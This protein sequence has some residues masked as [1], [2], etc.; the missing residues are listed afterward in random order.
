MMDP[1]I[2]ELNPDTM[3]QEQMTDLLFNSLSD[4]GKSGDCIF[5]FGS[6]KASQYRLPKAIQLYREGRANKI[7]FSGGAIWPSQ[8]V[9]ESILLYNHAIWLGVPPADLLV[10]PLSLNTKENV[11]ASLLVLDRFFELHNIKRLLIVTT[12]Y[13]MLRVYLTL[14]TYMPAWINYSFCAAEDPSLLKDNWFLSSK[15]RSIV[16]NESK[17]IIKYINLGAL[18]DMKTKN[19]LE[20]IR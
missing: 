14:K 11:L 3:S 8:H 13:H 19:R 12:N 1:N 15:G 20:G 5:V 4:D 9:P 7:L 17:K 16:K 6:R 18:N 2:S 10:E